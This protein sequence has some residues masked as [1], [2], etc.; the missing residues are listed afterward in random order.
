[1]YTDL[2]G[3]AAGF[4]EYEFLSAEELIKK[5]DFISLHIPHSKGEVPAIG[6][7]QIE[8]MKTGAYIINCARG[9]VVDE[10]ALLEAL[11]SGKIA[12]VALDVFEE[13]PTKNEE[14]INHPRVSVTPHIGAA[15]E[16]AQQR[17]GE[18]IVEIVEAL[19]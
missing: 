16:E 18:E 9:G 14:L 17:I 5:S 11:N 1:M 19:I 6:V 3:K 7:A 10:K 2:F 15:T 4:D 8:T 13:E 12:G